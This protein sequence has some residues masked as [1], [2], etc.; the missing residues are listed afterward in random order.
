MLSVQV[1]MDLLSLL[2]LFERWFYA[3]LRISAEARSLHLLQILCQ[4]LASF[5]DLLPAP[6]CGILHL[7]SVTSL[8]HS[9]VPWRSN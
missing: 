4:I 8:F 6:F 5:L 1:V 7:D 3:V 9:S 2:W